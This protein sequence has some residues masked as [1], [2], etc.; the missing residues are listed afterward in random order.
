VPEL[1]LD[2]VIAKLKRADS[3]YASL[4]DE[5]GAFL[6]RQPYTMRLDVDCKRG[7]YGLYV[8]G[9]REPPPLALSV[10]VGDFIHNLR[11]ALDHL[12]WQLVLFSGNAPGDRTQFPIFTSEPVGGRPLK[13][14]SRMTAGMNDLILSE[15]RRVQPYTAGDSAAFTALAILNA[16]SNEDKHR[17]PLVCV[18]AVARHAEGSTGVIQER[19][20]EI[21]SSEIL[22][23][24]PL[25]DGDEI[26]SGTIRCTGPN[27]QIGVKGPIPIDIAFRVG[28]HHVPTKGLVE[29]REA[30]QKIIALFT[31]VCSLHRT[32]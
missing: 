8:N 30:T 18:S 9:V 6:Q 22:T 13:A 15:I 11:S 31:A 2:G 32:P 16:L 10:I 5:I 1:Y 12:A 3:H 26:A 29:I 25:D 19:D 28:P 17:L 21:L 27:P 20:V 14:W 23:G 24:R 7:R 4:Q